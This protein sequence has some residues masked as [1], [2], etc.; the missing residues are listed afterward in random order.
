MGFETKVEDV[1]VAKDI[2][3]NYLAKRGIVVF[4][5]EINSIFKKSK[6]WF[7][8][9]QSVKFTGVAIIKSTTGEVLTTVKF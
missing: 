4:V 8:M 5:S 1:I 9:I 2:A 7:V 6:V 3:L